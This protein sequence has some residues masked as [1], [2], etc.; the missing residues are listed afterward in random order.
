[1]L[2]YSNNYFL[3]ISDFDCYD[4]LS[5][6]GALGIL[7]NISAEH[8]EQL[9]IGFKAMLQRGLL[10][11]ILRTKYTVEQPAEVLTTVKAETVL[12][13]PGRAAS[14]R[15]YRVY[16]SNDSVLLRGITQWAVI[17]AQTRRLMPLAGIMPQDFADD[18]APEFPDGISKLRDFEALGEPFC[19][20]PGFSF[21]DRNGHINNARYAELAA[22]ALEPSEKEAVKAFQIDFIHETRLGEQLKLYTARENGKA[23][24][25][26]VGEDNKSRFLCEIE[27]Q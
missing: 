14:V 24:V 7:Q 22:D 26:A 18:S 4:R 6:A 17:N 11:V 15:D 21:I 3:G 12:R 9:G 1:M 27:F 10:W 19:C 20:K 13:K 23:L 5:P 16:D 8:A 2:S 25:K